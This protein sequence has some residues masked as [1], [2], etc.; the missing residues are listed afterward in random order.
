M[1]LEKHVQFLAK[2]L[3]PLT[4]VDPLSISP[5]LKDDVSKFNGRAVILFYRTH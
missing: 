2:V 4:K 1:V 5:G 3:E